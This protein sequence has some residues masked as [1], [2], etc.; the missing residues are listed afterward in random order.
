MSRYIGLHYIM[1]CDITSHCITLYFYFC[2][3]MH[4][5]EQHSS[6]ITYRDPNSKPIVVVVCKSKIF[7]VNRV[8]RLLFPTAESPANT[9]EIIQGERRYKICLACHISWFMKD[10]RNIKHPWL[11]NQS[12]VS[13]E[14]VLAKGFHEAI[15]FTTFLWRTTNC[16]ILQQHTIVTSPSHRYVIGKDIYIS[17]S[18]QYQH[19]VH[20][21]E[22]LNFVKIILVSRI[23]NH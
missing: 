23:Q 14:M 20:T 9:T 21:I 10:S 16:R 19:I 13:H 3:F 7:L 4:S 22:W 8:T 15:G 1:S 5:I 17:H 6:Y 18:I 12:A 11:K 2:I